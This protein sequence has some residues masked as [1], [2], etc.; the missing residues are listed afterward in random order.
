[1]RVLLVV[2]TFPPQ[3]G[4]LV[5]M[6]PKYL[7]RL[8]VQVHVAAIDLPTYYNLD[9]FKGA[10][11]RFLSSQALRAGSV[12]EMDG[13]TVHVLRHRE[14][15]GYP[16]MRGLGRKIGE[17][18][19]DIVYCIMAIGW[20]PLQ[21]ALSKLRHRFKLFT[22][23]HTSAMMFSLAS[24]RRPTVA[25]RTRNLL[26]RWLP[27]RAVSLVTER[28]YCPTDDC[29]TVAWRYFGVQ[30]RK[31]E[32]VHLGVDTDYFYPVASDAHRQAR[33]ALRQRLGFA[34]DEIVCIYTG[35]MT[36]FKNPVLLA[37]ALEQ[38][39]ARGGRFRGLFIGDGAQRERLGR[40]P[41]SVVLDFMPFHAL[42]DYYRA[43]DV[44]VWLAN[45]STS[46]LDAAACGIPIIVSDRI[47]Q[48]HVTGNGLAY[49]LNDLSS[50]IEMLRTLES[51]ETRRRMGEAGAHKMRER[52]TW[53]LAARKRLHDFELVT[54]APRP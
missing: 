21:A 31:V 36:E 24:T 14:L 42:G 22:G 50:L 12:T 48:D 53:E 3:M 54:N 30:K 15:L 17:L 29:G 52:F 44:A 8:G 11:P 38:L 28:C 18:R 13:Y 49:R 43:A 25:A 37:E 47:Y 1:M 34:P 26:T 33:A 45:E 4:Y 32:I 19:P 2:E 10:V 35:K 41:A 6:L 51:A 16:Y 9:E 23:S 27:G 5:T 7:V 46:M 20:M 40:F 39:R